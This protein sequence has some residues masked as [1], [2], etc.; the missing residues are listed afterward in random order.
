MRFP[1][2]RSLK[3]LLQEKEMQN[4]VKADEAEDEEPSDVDSGH[5]TEINQLDVHGL[6][7]DLTDDSFA[8]DSD[9]GLE[10]EDENAGMA[11]MTVEQM[12]IL[13]G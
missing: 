9:L 11:G 1:D 4:R 13:N 12:A 10:E 5:D 3:E 8:S 7:A 2:G 6:H